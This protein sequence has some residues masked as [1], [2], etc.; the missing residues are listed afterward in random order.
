MVFWKP[1]QTKIQFV[2]VWKHIIIVWHLEITF[3]RQYLVYGWL[4]DNLL[5]QFLQC[6]FSFVENEQITEIP[7]INVIYLLPCNKKL[8]FFRKE[9][10][11]R[12]DAVGSFFC[13]A[14]APFKPSYTGYTEPNKRLILFNIISTT[15]WIDLIHYPMNGFYT[16][17]NE[18]VLFT[19]QWMDNTNTN[20][21]LSSVVE[22]NKGM[23]ETA[24]ALISDRW[25]QFLML[26]GVGGATLADKGT[27]KTRDLSKYNK[28]E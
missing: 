11:I 8:D 27:C 24:L 17:P 18:C 14:T 10:S 26:V 19:T 13:T 16:L 12:G 28:D 2:W 4:F 3:W 1:W 15:Q 5:K 25:R 21:N 9:L 6:Q 23:N 20:T 7:I 22:Y